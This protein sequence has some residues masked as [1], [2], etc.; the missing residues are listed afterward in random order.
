VHFVSKEA[1]LESAVLDITLISGRH[2]GVAIG[3]LVKEVLENWGI[4]KAT[5]TV[6]TDNGSNMIKAFKHGQELYL[7][8]C[9][10]VGVT[11]DETVL[12]DDESG[13]E[14]ILTFPVEKGI[15]SHFF[16]LYLFFFEFIN[17]FYSITRSGGSI[18]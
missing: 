9:P 3:R 13:I 18:N 6:I 5:P 4:T 16:V 8:E 7:A 15:L 10:T 11:E 1:K 2:T 17:E 12:S 14:D